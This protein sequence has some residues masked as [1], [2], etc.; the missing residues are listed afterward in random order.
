MPELINTPTYILNNLNLSNTGFIKKLYY[1]LVG[2]FYSQIEKFFSGSV[3][4]FFINRLSFSNVTT[5]LEDKFYVISENLISF[6][7]Q[8]KDLQECWWNK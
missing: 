6:N 3:Y 4:C 2:I 8:I 7:I 5:K 1:F